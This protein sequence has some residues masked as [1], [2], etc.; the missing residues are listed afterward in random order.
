[1]SVFL[2]GEEDALLTVAN[3]CVVLT[4]ITVEDAATAVFLLGM[5]AR[6]GGNIDLLQRLIREFFGE[7]RYAEMYAEMTEAFKQYVNNRTQELSA[8]HTK[9]GE[10]G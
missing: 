3:A 9:L 2:D 4:P 10:G 8:G 7:D 6:Y 1:M 5:M